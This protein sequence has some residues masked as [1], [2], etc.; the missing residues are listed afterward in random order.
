LPFL[1]ITFVDSTFGL[2]KIEKCDA[3]IDYVDGEAD[4]AL[5]P[6]FENAEAALEN[7]K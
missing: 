2:Q 5:Q 1:L 3:R 7:S 6:A 4:A